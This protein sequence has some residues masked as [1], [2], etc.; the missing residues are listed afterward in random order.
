MKSTP[1]RISAFWISTL[2]AS[3]TFLVCAATPWLTKDFKDWTERD[4]S[5]L[6]TD[7]PWARVMP[8]PSTDRPEQ[9]VL[10]GSPD[11][12]PQSSA[13]LGNNS[14]NSSI[15][16]ANQGPEGGNPN[17]SPVLTPA[18]L[19]QSTGAPAIEPTITIIWA[20]ALPVRLAELK[21]RTKESQPTET[22]I[23]AAMK[24][25]EHYTIV[26]VG[27]PEPDNLAQVSALAPT[28]SIASHRKAIPCSTS[29][30]RKLGDRNIY[31]FRFPKTVTFAPDDREVEFRV[32]LGRMQIR[33]KFELR[34]MTYRGKLAL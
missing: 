28:A 10:E 34:D 2:C 27:L 4:A 5:A 32:T 11:A 8:L 30:F 6:V 18:A 20:S 31:I 33:K 3:S 13:A 7:S 22:Q 24:P 17:R 16:S 29:D 23:Q 21:L 14:S 12:G 15:T 1:V 26:V 19:T 9:M 25:R